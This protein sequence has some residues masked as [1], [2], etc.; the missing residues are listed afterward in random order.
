MWYKNHSSVSTVATAN[1]VSVAT[2][3]GVAVAVW[4]AKHIEV[5]AVVTA[6]GVAF[7]IIA[8]V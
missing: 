4:Y 1:A 3:I 2:R 6:T 7:V 5:K 8:F